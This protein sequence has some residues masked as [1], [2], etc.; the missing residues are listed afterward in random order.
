[1]VYSWKRERVF[2]TCLVETG[3]VDAYT[4]LPIGL[5]DDNRVGQPP[6]VVDLS[7]KIGVKQLF[8]FF[9]DKV[10]LLN[11][12]LLE[13]LLDWSGIEVDL[14]MVLNHLRRDPGHL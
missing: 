5:R 2:R 1:L 7:D 3:V 6:R 11:G 9:T 8:D 12:L 4:K 13:L 10:L 14:Q